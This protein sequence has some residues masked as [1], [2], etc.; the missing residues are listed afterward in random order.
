MVFPVIPVTIMLIERIG[1]YL[2]S[3]LKKTA[4][5]IIQ[6]F[7]KDAPI[8]TPLLCVSGVQSISLIVIPKKINI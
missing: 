5:L 3:A 6:M 1:V 8:I 2:V 4:N 7:L